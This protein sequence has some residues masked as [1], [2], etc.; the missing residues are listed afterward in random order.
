MSTQP[1]AKAKI[2]TLID[3][4]KE[5]VTTTKFHLQG[6]LD[7]FPDV[8]KTITEALGDRNTL[9]YSEGKFSNS[10]ESRGIDFTVG[11]DRLRLGIPDEIECSY[12]EKPDG[13]VL[14]FTSGKQMKFSKKVGFF[15]LGTLLL[16]IVVSTK[17]VFINM[18]KD[19]ADIRI[20]VA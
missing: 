15:S 6:I 12:T 3:Q 11:K 13:F 8:P 18:D 2:Q 19:A 10:G 17:E 20:P 1:I 16:G 5:A 7:I 9:N 14:D 4:A